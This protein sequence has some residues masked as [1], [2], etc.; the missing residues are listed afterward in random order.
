MDKWQR[1]T[2]YYSGLLFGSMLVFAVLYQ[3]GMRVYR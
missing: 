3:N 2:L 1:R